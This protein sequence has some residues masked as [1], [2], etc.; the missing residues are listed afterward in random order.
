MEVLVVGNTSYVDDDFCVK[1]FPGDHVQVVAASDV[2]RDGSSAPSSW[3][4]LLQHLDQ[5]YEFDRVVYLSTYLT[6][7]TETFGDIELLRSV[8]RACLGRQIQLLFVT[9]PAG[10][11][12]D[13]D[14]AGQ[15][16]KGIIAH[17]A[18]D[19]CRYYAGRDGIQAKILRVPYLY[20]AS[21]ALNDPFLVPLFQA[22]S[23]GSLVLKNSA[24]APLQ[25]LCAEELAVLVRRIFDSW[26]P[27]FEELGVAD[28]FAHTLGDLAEALKRLFPVLQVTFGDDAEASVSP[29]DAVRKRYGWF[30]R[31]DVLTDLSTIHARWEQS[32]A[33]KRHPLHYAIDRMREHTL[34][35]MCMETAL[36]WVLFECLERVFSQSA[37]LNVLDYRLLY[38]VLIGTLYGLDFGLVAALLASIG[39]AASYFT[40][41]GYTFQGLFYEP[42]NWLP[43]IAY[44]VVG[45][46]CGY[47][48]LRNRE[49][50][51]AER[52]ENELVRNRN[53]FLGRLYHDAI[54]DKQAYKRQIVGRHDSFGKIFAVT[55]E[56]DVLNPRD[57]Y[58]K[59]CELLGEILENDSV[60]IYHVSGGA[61]T[62][63]VAASP[64]ISADAL[65]SLAL[66]DL[67]AMMEGVDHSG[68]WVNR[69]LVPGLPMFAYV[70]ER[71]GAPSIFIFVRHVAESQMTLYY[72][73]L[74]RILCGLVES[75]L[76]RAFDYEAVAQD[77]R[78]IAGTRV[79]KRD[80]FGREL[81]TEQAL[82][83]S[84]MGS[85]LLLRVVPGMEPV[86]E[87]VGAIGSAIRESD[88]AGLVDD[89]LYLLMRQAIEADLPVI[90]KRMASKQIT[91]EHVDGEGAVALL[92]QIDPAGSDGEGDAA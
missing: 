38:V 55:Q 24:D 86:G 52:A 22:C 12:G 40:Q 8:F 48:Q 16:G 6:P 53:D 66:D 88:A 26:D 37:Q 77:K 17:A 23:H 28:S 59:C 74:F 60:T 64:A 75:A 62:R 81:A 43:F 50:L 76:G 3:N 29:S 15:T 31:Y 10:A 89:T 11:E 4:E 87:L 58:R 1:A 25:A 92:R 32:R 19:L 70:M 18:N 47:V 61:F 73:N 33:G 85:Y 80:A 9:G 27:A 79:L 2:Q 44:F 67:K 36:A 49:A 90:F 20:T 69:K 41:Y 13:V 34:P 82:A 51:K 91:V 30:Q 42:S 21:P 54:E 78:C 71:D 5:A 68:L 39:L 84:K 57:I 45:A 46:V 35:V 65:R 83:D 14:A 72:Q 7:H 63:L 56:L